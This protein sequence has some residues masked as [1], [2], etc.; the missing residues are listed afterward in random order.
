MAADLRLVAEQ[1]QLDAAAYEQVRHAQRRQRLC[2]A[3]SA[4]CALVV[5]W[6]Q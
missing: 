6:R 3:V 5:I 4:L 1:D 2:M